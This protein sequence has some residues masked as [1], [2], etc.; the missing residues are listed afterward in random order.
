M[1][2]E[3]GAQETPKLSSRVPHPSWIAWSKGWPLSCFFLHHFYPFF[4]LLLLHHAGPA[5]LSEA[6]RPLSQ[7]AGGFPLFPVY[8]LGIWK[9]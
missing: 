1:G 5:C 8:W 6:P 9:D 4:H 3:P 2:F 7:E